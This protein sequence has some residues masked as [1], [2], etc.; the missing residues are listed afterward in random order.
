MTPTKTTKHIQDALDRLWPGLR[1]EYDWQHSTWVITEGFYYT[2]N[3]LPA[4]D[5]YVVPTDAMIPVSGLRPVNRGVLCRLVWK[6]DPLDDTH[7]GIPVPPCRDLIIS[8]LYRMFTNAR[9]EGV[10]EQI[11]RLDQEELEVSLKRT[12]EYQA[13]YRDTA[14][15]SWKRM[16]RRVTSTADG[17]TDNRKIER[18][19][20]KTMREEAQE[21]RNRE[22]DAAVRELASEGKVCL[23]YAGSLWDGADG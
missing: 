8:Q 10:S 11:D 16:R 6:S 19:I 15:Q 1:L 9:E 4:K 13:A 3:G 18:S 22:A 12:S 7:P 14:E 23:K 21:E 17:Y 2:D 5:L 20:Q